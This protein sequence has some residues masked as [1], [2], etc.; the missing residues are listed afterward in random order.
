MG[1]NDARTHL[2]QEVLITS[3]L[4]A[5][6][7]RQPDFELENRALNSV[8]ALLAQKAMAVPELLVEKIR[9]L[10]HAESSGIS[11]LESYGGE[12]VFRWV[13][14][15]GRCANVLG[16]SIERE[17]SPCGVVIEQDD[18]LL[19]RDPHLCFPQLRA[20]EPQIR[21]ALLAPFYVDGRVA[22][23]VWAVMHSTA[24]VFDREDA[25]VLHSL[26]QFASVVIRA[27][28]ALEQAESTGARLKQQLTDLR[29]TN[30]R[31]HQAMGEHARLL[32]ALAQSE[33]RYR[34]L[35]AQVKDYAIF[36]MD[37][38][39]HALSWNEGVE[40]VLGYTREEFVGS[41]LEL[42][43]LPA[44]VAEG[45]PRREL[46]LARRE[47][48]TSNDR[49]L[50]RKGGR[51]FFAAG[52]TTKLTDSRGECIG[53]T[54]VLR[55]ETQRVLAED[56]RRASEARFRAL[57]QN[58]RDYAIFMI[59][60]TGVI[61]Q[62]TEGAQRVKGY[63]AEEVLGK[64]LSTF[65]TPEDIAAGEPTLELV[66]AEKEGRVER[67]GWRIRKG[68]ERFWVNEI[69]TAVRGEDGKLLGFTKISRDL[70][71]R[72]RVEEALL[73]AD[74]RKDEFLATLAHELR[75]PLAPLR[76]GLQIMRL[77]RQDGA[78]L[79]GTVEMM[80]RQLRHL[81]RLVD[82]L[83]DVARITSGKVELRRRRLDLRQVLAAS[84]EASRPAIDVR[85]H[86][87]RVEA[88]QEDVAVEGD[89]D[90]LIQVFSN[91]LSN[92]A[93][94]TH[95]G[96][97]IELTLVREGDHAVVSVIDSGVGIPSEDLTRVF[98]L[99]SQVRTHQRH[100]EGGLG[101]GLSLVRSLVAL[102]GGS[103]IAESAGTGAGS[104]FTV[105]LPLLKSRSSNRRVNNE[106]AA[107]AR[108]PT[109]R[110]LIADDNADAAGALATLLQLEG[111]DVV[112]AHDGEEAV[113][114]ASNFRPDLVFLDL[115]MPVMD[116]FEAAR[117]LRALPDGEGIFLI[118]LTGW[119]QASDRQRSREAGFD[120]HLVKPVDSAALTEV[121]TAGPRWLGGE[122]SE[123][124]AEEAPKTDSAMRGSTEE[125][126]RPH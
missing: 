90:R 47:G 88:G 18:V 23:T 112:V 15:A 56:E 5:R 55:D 44:D 19:F 106:G 116:G 93:K 74:Q 12:E 42:L 60:P 28:R 94:Y 29:D 2:L 11:L 118:A 3:E 117:R 87:L 98:D 121:L 103:V 95:Q 120:R 34:S 100:A 69:A 45:L 92:A 73:N 108:V 67:E 96:G 41:E 20:V 124:A 110:V 25:R 83:L 113:M 114:K 14:V 65:Y 59:D 70:T 78:P 109:R 48:V 10:C 32:E 119:G 37:L 1:R 79:Q 35:I 62:W 53:F 66:Q 115:G 24:R 38:E 80:D 76:T 123:T 8:A 40:A 85:G 82:D 99:F 4:A 107:R 26:S 102:H 49:W 122:D 58:V 57:V 72:K 126:D 16:Q 31:L 111:H 125:L 54:K 84:V 9:E 91:L 75:N 89:F 7:A 104:Q 64:H 27:L 101:I 52:R 30:E 97:R 36:G 13:A 61:T 63:T 77:A 86:A 71:D 51:P 68:G 6:P 46:E 43:Y 21:E 81:V 39:G 33:S 22:G 17:Q 105:R 50:R